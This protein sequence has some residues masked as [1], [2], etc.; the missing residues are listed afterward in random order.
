MSGR[1]PGAPNIESLWKNLCDGVESL[2]FF[3]DKDLLASGVSEHLFKNPRYVK[4]GAILDNVDLFDAGLFGFSPREAEVMDP[5]HRIFLECAWDVLERAGYD[6]LNCKGSVGV[7]AGSNLSTYLLMLHSDPKVRESVN[8]LQAILG[9]DKDS[10]TTMVSYKLNLRGPSIA[11]QTFC[12]TSLVAVHM[13]CQSLRNG[14]C[15]MA[16]AGGI[17]VVVP[18]HQGYLYESGGLAPSDG[19][20]RSFDAKATGSILGN[21]VGVVC[22]KRLEDAL[23]DGDQI[24]AVIIGSAINNDGSMK[25][26]YTAPSVAGQSEAILAALDDAGVEPDSISYV[27]AHGSATELGDP[28]EVAALTKAFSTRTEAKNFCALG[29]VKSN[30]GHLDRAAGVTA[31]IKTALALERR[32]IPPSI[33]FE[34]PNPK[35]DF[36]NSPFYVNTILSE[37]RANGSPLRAGVNSLGMG[38]T[39][40][41]L[42]LEEAPPAQPSTPGRPWQLLVLSGK[43]EKAL[44]SVTDN[45]SDHLIGAGELD[46]ADVAYTLQLGRRALDFRRILV[47]RDLDDARKVLADKDPRRLQTAYRE[48]GERPLVFMFPG[49]GGQYINMGRGLYD[50]EPVFRKEVDRCSEIL[51]RYLGFDLRKELYPDDAPSESNDVQPGSS[52]NLRAML[53]R[54][55]TKAGESKLDRTSVSQPLL[56]VIEYALAQLW[57]A[58]GMLPQALVGYSLGEYVAACLAGVFSLEDGLKLVAERARLIE[59][60]PAGALLAVGLSEAEIS[61]L[62]GDDLSQ[63]GRAHV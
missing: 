41:H 21:G 62:L 17:R 56:F 63:I 35:I 13:A 2:T 42:I 3:E 32:Q 31:L 20:T 6:P 26:G 15:D 54:D 5:Q 36:A 38:G 61:P 39:N 46:L 30:F 47:C 7:F 58:W 29:S 49:L 51:T 27:E 28:I 4:A 60:L 55:R 37:W 25:A 12:S 22:L 34:D 9:N 48:E 16:L 40:A 44:E 45:F 8:M 24:S 43:T 23:A 52:I 33:N 53:G 10:L 59:T 11:V 57:M 19:H 1:F 14:E 18:D 50:C